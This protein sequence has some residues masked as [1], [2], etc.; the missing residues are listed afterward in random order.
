MRP[1]IKKHTPAKE[2]TFAHHT[3]DKEL[4][5]FHNIQHILQAQQNKILITKCDPDN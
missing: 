1:Q 2:K 4:L 5:I 3:S